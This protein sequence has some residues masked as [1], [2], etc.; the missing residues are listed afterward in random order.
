[1]ERLNRVERR[2]AIMDRVRSESFVVC[3][4]RATLAG[5]RRCGQTMYRAGHCSRPSFDGRAT[6]RRE[7]RRDI[8]GFE[9]EYYLVWGH[10]GLVVHSTEVQA[11][12][13]TA[14]SQ[15]PT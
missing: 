4:I 2:R 11:G 1:M 6:G 13:G 8:Y 3:Y 9:T 12:G 7:S 5:E 15:S 10:L 14:I